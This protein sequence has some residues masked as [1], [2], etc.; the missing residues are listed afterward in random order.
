MAGPAPL[1]DALGYL[2]LRPWWFA[3]IPLALVLGIWLTRRSGS[4]G[5]WERVVDPELM[6]AM[7]RMGRVVPGGRSRAVLP[8]CVLAVLGLALAGPS[9]ER[10]DTASFRNLDGVVLVLDLSPSVTG[11]ARFFDVL[12][13]ARLVAEA[14]G[15]RQIALIVFAGEAYVAAPFSTDARALSGTLAL[16]DARTMPVAGS[17]PEAGL[18]LARR[19]LE[20]ADMLAADVVL[21]SDG[22]ATGPQAIAE[23]QRLGAAG[24]TVSTIATKP[25][26]GAMDALARAGGGSIASVDDPFPVA[27]AIG[28]RSVERLAATDYAML[29]LEDRGRFLLLLALIPA[30]LMLPRGRQT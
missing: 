16:M 12:T 18:V 2:W 9:A 29:V 25:E 6:A 10:R 11:D 8:A 22:A 5:A 3:L 24:W 1:I 13:A 14:A 7:R 4:L 20:S 30:F 26:R 23:A 15:T 28:A 27:R 21:I 19:M 17:R